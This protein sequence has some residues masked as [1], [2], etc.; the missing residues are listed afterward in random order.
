MKQFQLAFAACA[1]LIFGAIFAQ[2][3]NAQYGSLFV[4]GGSTAQALA[5]TA[6]KMTGFATLGATNPQ[7]TSVT[8]ALAADTITVKGGG[9]YMVRFDSTALMG[10][11][12]IQVTYTLR[13]GATAITG[14]ACAFEAEDVAV[15]VHTGF[16]FIYE[17]AADAVL[18]IYVASESATPN[19]TP[20]HAQFSVVRMD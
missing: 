10:T 16:H 14:A 2:E 1:A 13:N 17:P 8:P 20:V 5:T 7:D 19:L 4:S 6:A 11:A 3:S 9:R 18:S 12:D 15:P